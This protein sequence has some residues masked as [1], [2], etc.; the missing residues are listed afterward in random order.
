MTSTTNNDSPSSRKRKRDEDKTGHSKGKAGK[1]LKSMKLRV[2]KGAQSNLTEWVN[3]LIDNPHTSLYKRLKK[4]FDQIRQQWPKAK[5]DPDQI[6]CHLIDEK[7]SDH[8]RTST[9]AYRLLADQSNL[10]ALPMRV[11]IH[12]LAM[13][14]SN[15]KVPEYAPPAHTGSRIGAK[16]TWH[17]SHL[18]HNKSCTNSEH[19][20]WEPS[21]Y[22]R[23]R[24]GCVGRDQ[25]RHLPQCLRSHRRTQIDWHTMSNVQ[26][27]ITLSSAAA[28]D[29]SDTITL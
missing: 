21:W 12:H 25:C 5:R 13:I 11:A 26:I 1:L 8:V 29:E 20:V 4:N 17:C 9:E 22:N 19:L 18:C 24:D 27:N 28:I 3:P 14:F 7:D 16:P 23:Q 6:D 15:K 2:N 10:S